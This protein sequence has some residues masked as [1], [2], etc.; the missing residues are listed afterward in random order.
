MEAKKY[1]RC[2][3][4]SNLFNYNENHPMTCTSNYQ[5]DKIL[6]CFGCGEP[7]KKY[8]MVFRLR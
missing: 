8:F 1:I 3:Y 5:D 4:C 6:W 2:P 7:N